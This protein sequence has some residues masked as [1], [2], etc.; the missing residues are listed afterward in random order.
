[1]TVPVPKLSPVTAELSCMALSPFDA[2]T[3]MLQAPNALG[4]TSA[5]AALY[6][7]LLKQDLPRNSLVLELGSGSGVLSIMLALQRPDLAITGIEI[8]KELCAISCHNASGLQLSIA[9]LHQDLRTYTAPRPFQLIFANPPW[10]VLGKGIISPNPLRAASRSETSCTMSDVFA[11]LSRNLASD[12]QAILLYPPSRAS[13]ASAIANQYGLQLHFREDY[14]SPWSIL[15][16][17][18]G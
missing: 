2:N 15:H 4:A 16:Y 14:P 10:Q 13:E 17:T 1:M 9:F 3:W 8:Q 5:T 12:G 6:A 18:K 7:Y 11:C